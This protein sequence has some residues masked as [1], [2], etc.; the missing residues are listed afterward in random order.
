MQHGDFSFIDSKIKRYDKNKVQDGSIVT[1]LDYIRFIY[2]ELGKQYRNEYFYKNTFINT[3]LLKKYGV[4]DTILFNEFRVGKSVADLVMINGESKVFEI[5]TELD[6]K[7]RLHGQIADYS[8]VFNKCYVIT[9][10][11]LVEKYA[12]EDKSVGIIALQKNPRSLQMKEIRSPQKNEFVNPDVLMR[13]LRTNEYKKIV[14]NY[15]GELPEMNSFNMFNLCLEL[16]REIPQDELSE[17]FHTEI[18]NRKSIT[19]SLGFVNKELRQL[20]LALNLNEKKYQHL[21]AQ[22]SSP[23]NF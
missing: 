1:Y 19:T 7:K 23:I 13:C 22:L 2:R 8:K 21:I 4:K 10:E 9:D 17:L 6:S 15:Y 18:K 5:K 16:I 11:S 20:V 14:Q 12:K 3:L